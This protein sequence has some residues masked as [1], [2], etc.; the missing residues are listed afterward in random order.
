M[1]GAQM[2]KN[3]AIFV[4]LVLTGFAACSQGVKSQSKAVPA[5]VRTPPKT[6]PMEAQQAFD[7][8]TTAVILPIEGENY[9]KFIQQ[10]GDKG[11]IIAG[12]AG[13]FASPG[14][15]ML[16]IKTDNKGKILW[17]K[18]PDKGFL[19]CV[20]AINSGFVIA[21]LKHISDFD[22]DAYFA[23]LD[24]S[25]NTLWTMAYND[26]KKISSARYIE[27]PE[28]GGYSLIIMEFKDNKTRYFRVTT[29]LT[30]NILSKKLLQ[31]SET[32]YKEGTEPVPGAGFIAAS[33]ED[34]T[35]KVESDGGFDEVKAGRATLARTDTDGN[36]IWKIRFTSNFLRSF[37][38]AA[39][40]TAD[41]GYIFAG[42]VEWNEKGATHAFLVKTDKDG[43]P[44]W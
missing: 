18:N 23:G 7:I 29:G 27:Q 12:D 1:N 32:G 28:E 40:Q 44:G 24:A 9:I 42:L 30:G 6:I 35:L 5:P 16:V 11:Y 14:K 15:D 17:L 2:K 41:N 26:D 10:T 43:K 20:R 34:E 22:S 39:A 33:Q 8:T 25:G 38:C 3:P 36:E 37:G 19:Y 21:G 31:E 4:I 13:T